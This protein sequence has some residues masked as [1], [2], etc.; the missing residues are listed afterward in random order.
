MLDPILSR[1]VKKMKGL[2]VIKFNE[3]DL[4]YN[5]DFKIYFS[6]KYGN[7][8]YTPEVSAKVTIVNF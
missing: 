5:E 1:Q 7:P 2:L 3:K 8:H 6:T 4:N